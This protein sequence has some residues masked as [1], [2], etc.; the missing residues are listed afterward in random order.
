[1]KEREFLAHSERKPVAEGMSP[2]DASFDAEECDVPGIADRIAVAGSEGHAAP[3]QG[4]DC[5]RWDRVLEEY[6]V[7]IESPS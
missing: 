2:D 7:E 4:G 6:E 5:T 3:G 1:M